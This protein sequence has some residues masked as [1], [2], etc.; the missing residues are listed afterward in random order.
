M[1]TGKRRGQ[2]VEPGVG[3]GHRPP[4][5]SVVD[6]GQHEVVCTGRHRDETCFRVWTGTHALPQRGVFQINAGELMGG[7]EV[8]VGQQLHL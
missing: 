1:D 8:R 2:V 5:A 3:Y 4:V 6:G 7:E